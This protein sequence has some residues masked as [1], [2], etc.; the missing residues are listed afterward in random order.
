MSNGSTQL[1]R[2]L[3][4]YGGSFGGGAGTLGLDTTGGTRGS[5]SKGG[6]QQMM[7]L[8]AEQLEYFQGEREQ[9]KQI[10]EE[11]RK[12]FESFKFENPFADVKNPYADLK[13]E[14]ENLYEGMENP[15]EDLTVNMRAAEFQAEQG[16]LQRANILQTLRGAA[17]ASGVASLAQSLANQGIAQAEQISANIA[18]QESSNRRLAAQG[19]MSIR[20]MELQGAERAR[21]LGIS[22]EQLVA[23]GGFQADTMRRQGEAAIQQAE[24]GRESTL[25]GV[26]FGLMAGA[27][28]ALSQ[29][30][31]NQ[32]SAFGMQI[33]AANQRSS[34]KSGFLNAIISAGATIGAAKISAPATCLPKGVLIDTPDGKK[35]IENINVGDAVIGY[36]GKPVLVVQKHCYM[37]NPEDTFYKV[38]IKH[39][40]RVGLV[41]VSGWHKIVG[42]RASEI[43]ENVISKKPYTGVEF[44]YD[45]LTEDLGYRI[46]GI[47]VNSMIDELI[48]LSVKLKNERNK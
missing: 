42:T 6:M 27:N 47:P 40:G 15:Y 5:G 12:Q 29:A 2:Q 44:S 16:A 7:D 10:L 43:S 39:D 46:D 36:S 48:E 33:N 45:L 11:Q 1:E 14:F 8:A 26:E 30:M 41:D 3:N 18:L 38:K 19:E 35:L 23:Q 34:Q 4:K 21:A 32:M 25:L 28:E 20:Q 13:T 17:G 22:R 9:Q 24:F 37:Q 31:A